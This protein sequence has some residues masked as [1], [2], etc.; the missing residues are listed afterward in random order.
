MKIKYRQKIFL[1]IVTLLLIFGGLFFFSII[2]HE[3]DL[4]R[5]VFVSDQIVY[6]T[7]IDGYIRQNNLPLDSLSSLNDMVGLFP[8][9]I[10]V[11]V[12]DEEG[13]FLYNNYTNEIDTV[14]NQRNKTEIKKALI[15]GNGWSFR[16]SSFSKEESM[17]Y[18]LYNN[19]GKYI[20][21]ITMPFDEDAISF[22]SPNKGSLYF[23]LGAIVICLCLFAAFYFYYQKS[24][25]KFTNFVLTFTQ[26]KKIESVPLP[27]E[28]REI[29]TLIKR[30]YGQLEENKKEIILERE[31][32]L[33]HFHYS[34]EGIS[35][36]TKE[37][38]NIYTN[39]YFIQCLNMLFNEPTFDVHDLFTNPIFNE[40]IRFVEYPGDKTEFSTKVYGNNAHFFI[41]VILFEDKSFEIII[42][43]VTDEEKA[44]LDKTEIMNSIA[45][46]LKT[47]ITGI[48]G[49]LE[50]LIEHDH[51]PKEKKKEFIERAYNQT[52]RLSEII[53]DVALLS[54]A[55]D[56]RQ[57]LEL[58]D[59]NLYEL[60]L[61]QINEDAREVIEKRSATIKLN[62]PED[63]V[64]KGNNTLLYSL[65]F[66]LG[67]NAMKYAGENVTIT[68]NNY[69]ED[70]NYYYFSFADN[71]VGIEEKH[72]THI[73][74]QFYRINEGRTRDKGGSGL[75][76]SIVKEAVSFHNGTIRVKNRAEGGLEFLF[77]LRKQ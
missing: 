28:W 27:D 3:K 57:F 45:H 52:I 5:D 54:K 21:L 56:A 39:S 8:K 38:K 71:G 37:R 72:L 11:T 69:L 75:G 2:S 70:E 48:R 1:I 60:L 59:V 64:V 33:E 35:F 67:N 18:A 14:E 24:I 73:F 17:F 41:R 58:E 13:E 4:K 36:F 46:E 74:E 42:R 7:I 16:E 26:T 10:R 53:K 6:A 76:L 62:V 12:L 31:K 19:E 77:T 25:Q 50:T 55:S 47:P 49:C 15:K 20:V 65:F 43:D 61:Q 32:L 22:L 34:E 63:V 9:A 51:L 66:N 68:I 40:V 29:G 30:I 44:C 23:Q